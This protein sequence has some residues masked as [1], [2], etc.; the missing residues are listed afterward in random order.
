MAGSNL[1]QLARELQNRLAL[2]LPQ[3][4]ALPLSRIIE[5]LRP[6]HPGPDFATVRWLG[7]LYFFTS[8]QAAVVKVLWEAWE[9]GTPA[10]RQETILMTASSESDKLA[11]LFREHPAWGTMIIPSPVRGTFRLAD[12][13]QEFKENQPH[14]PQ[15]SHE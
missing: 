8:T 2:E 14:A 13:S 4:A 10:L 15:E 12:A 3:L 9:N 11:P 7:R 5:A 6:C 1:Y